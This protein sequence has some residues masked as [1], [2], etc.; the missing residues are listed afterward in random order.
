[1]YRLRAWFIA[2]PLIIIATILFAT[3]S[4]LVSFF[5]RA[6]RRQAAIARAWSKVLLAVSGITVRMQGR[7]KIASD[8]S[9]IFASS[10]ASYMDTPVILANIPVQFRF[11]AKKGLFSVPF[12]GWHLT[13]AGHVPV[14]RDNPRAA[15]KTM[16]LAADNVQ[17]RGIS[18][19]VFPE[20]GRTE[21]G[22]LQEFKDGAAYMAIRA[23][24]P[25]VPVALI[26]TRAVLP[27]GSGTPRSGTVE[28]RVGDPIPTAGLKL[29][30]R[31]RL[32]QQVRDHVVTLLEEKPVAHVSPVK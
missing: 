7:E 32:T 22:D 17:K 14:Y 12:L 4:I 24:V 1:M 2:D 20:G 5:D 27:F 13:R 6:G 11:L 21:T 23:G 9:Y 15:V 3:A 8:G 19:L 25:I 26:G 29:H 28:M 31:S 18:L 16:G 30:D 10:H